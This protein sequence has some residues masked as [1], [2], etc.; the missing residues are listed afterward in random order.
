MSVTLPGLGV[1]TLV[2]ELLDNYRRL[3]EALPAL[4]EAH[5]TARVMRSQVGNLSIVVENPD[6]TID[7]WGH[8]DVRTGEINLADEPWQI[9]EPPR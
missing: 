2:T 1:A 8:I 7:S 3:V 6:G 9:A 4:I 5:P